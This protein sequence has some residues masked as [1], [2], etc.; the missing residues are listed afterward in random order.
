MREKLNKNRGS[1]V[2]YGGKWARKKKCAEIRQT[3]KNLFFSNPKGVISSQ[4]M[5][6]AQ[7][8]HE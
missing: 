7:N 5:K 4:E 3:K 1:L 2:V 8:G 6:C